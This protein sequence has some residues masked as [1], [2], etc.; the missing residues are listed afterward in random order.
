M[1]IG[2]QMIG[3]GRVSA[4]SSGPLCRGELCLPSFLGALQLANFGAA[5]ANGRLPLRA[6]IDEAGAS[7][8]P[9]K[10]FDP[11]GLIGR[12]QGSNAGDLVGFNPC[13]PQGPREALASDVGKLD[14]RVLAGLTEDRPGPAHEGAAVDFG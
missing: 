13:L 12:R 3:A 9:V 1:V 10:R 4:H 11:I 8:Q 14:L 7:Y 6:A 5:F 2:F